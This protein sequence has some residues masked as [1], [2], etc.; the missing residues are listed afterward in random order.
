MTARRLLGALLLSTTAAA[1]GGRG[2]V[3]SPDPAR[4]VYDSASLFRLITQADPFTAYA[5]FP[6]AD[7]LVQG[8]LNGSEAHR[9]VVRVSMNARALAALQDGR[10]PSGARFPAG[11][12]IFK[13]VRARADAPTTTYAVM[14]KDPGNPLAAEGWVWAEFS[15][16]G[17]AGYPPDNRGVACTSCHQREEGRQHDL[18]RTFERQR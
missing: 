18:V 9:P 5:L 7:E 16:G 13:E 11:S 6:N 12:V 2:G 15:P 10:L 14:Y 1:C 8:R 4:D 17:S 3:P